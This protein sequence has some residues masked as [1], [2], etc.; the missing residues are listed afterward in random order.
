VLVS[1]AWNLSTPLCGLRASCPSGKKERSSAESEGAC[2][3]RK[4]ISALSKRDCLATFWASSILDKR[5]LGGIEYELDGRSRAGAKKIIVIADRASSRWFD[6][7]EA[8][9]ERG[10]N[11]CAHALDEKSNTS[12]RRRELAV[13]IA[14]T[15]AH[16]PGDGGGDDPNRA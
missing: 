9:R 5:V 14:K 15:P 12:V 6:G 3:S 13:A 11:V 16:C 1:L 8:Q 7:G 4:T 2:T 10:A